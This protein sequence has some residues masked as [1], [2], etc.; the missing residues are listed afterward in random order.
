MSLLGTRR[1]IKTLIFVVTVLTGSTIIGI[2]LFNKQN[3]PRADEDEPS[4]GFDYVEYQTSNITSEQF[5][6]LEYD[7]PLAHVNNYSY[8]YEETLNLRI[9]LTELNYFRLPSKDDRQALLAQQN[10]LSEDYDDNTRL[11]ALVNYLETQPDGSYAWLDQFN[12]GDFA[13]PDDG[14]TGIVPPADSF[15]HAQ[16]VMTCP[17]K[18]VQAAQEKKDALQYW[19]DVGAN[20]DIWDGFYQ[21]AQTKFRSYA[22]NE[23]KDLEPFLYKQYWSAADLDFLYNNIFPGSVLKTQRNE[24]QFVLER[25]YLQGV[26]KAYKTVT[27]YRSQGLK[28][29]TIDI[30]AFFFPPARGGKG[31]AALGELAAGS[32][33]LRP[34]ALGYVIFKTNADSISMPIVDGALRGG[35]IN[36]TRAFS[37]ASKV[38]ID[39]L[40]TDRVGQQIAKQGPKA[41][42]YLFR[43]R[44]VPAGK[45][46]GELLAQKLDNTFYISTKELAKRFARDVDR[47]PIGVYQRATGKVLIDETYAV[48]FFTRK[49]WTTTEADILHLHIHEYLHSIS[50][51][52][53]RDYYS[54]K[55]RYHP[56]EEGFTEFFTNRILREFVSGTYWNG[57]YRLETKFVE[58][59][60]GK[61]RDE[62]LRNAAGRM[63][64]KQAE[65]A[66]TNSFMRSYYSQDSVVFNEFMGIFIG[67]TNPYYNA[68]K[69]KLNGDVAEFITT[70]LERGDKEGLRKFIDSLQ[71]TKG[72]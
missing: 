46:T 40:L 69:V 42:D 9:R 65:Q 54:K 43:S 35:S 44:Y 14:D 26:L 48:S 45:L 41:L 34:Y 61:L 29:V 2:G 72:R 37:L 60:F 20:F 7:T 38:S 32:R 63:T 39:K 15:A 31:I 4:P 51:Q 55:L 52:A 62:T 49:S 71:I 57:S 17:T 18:E 50:F 30:A 8:S 64:Y 27:S 24:R 10:A 53:F 22:R 23:G 56:L 1:W 68:I 12:R 11:V 16:G 5:D 21:R 67:R 66:V 47:C 28:D 13:C 3:I 33:V 36:L 70:K 6:N 19:A 25:Q 59:L 58:D